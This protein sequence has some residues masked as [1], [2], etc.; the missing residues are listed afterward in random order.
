MTTTSELQKKPDYYID[1]EKC[2][3]SRRVKFQTNMR[4]KNFKQTHFTAGDEEQ[5]DRY[6]NMVNGQICEGKISLNKNIFKDINTYTSWDKYQN[7]SANAVSNTFRYLFYKFKKSIFVK[8]LNNKLSVFLP[9][10]NAQYLN[11]WSKEIHIQ[12]KHKTP[13][14]FMLYISKLEGRKY[15]SKVNPNINEWYANNCLIRYEQPLS[16]GESNISVIK[17]MLEAL[18]SK[19]K[20]DDVEFFINRRDFPLLKKNLTEPYD[21]MWGDDKKLVSHSYEKYTP[22]LS[23]SKTD[24]YADVL[25]PTYEDWSRV[26]LDDGIYFSDTCAKEYQV[27]FGIQWKDKKPIAVFRGSTT[28]CGVTINDNMRIKVSWMSSKGVKDKKGIKYLD[29]GIT[30]WNLRP[31]KLKNQKYLQTIEI[32]DLLF[33]LVEPL[34]PMEQAGYKYI[35]N[36]DGH[37]SAFR[38]SLELGMGSVVLLV[39]SPWKIWYSDMLVPYEHYIPVKED[40][41]D[42]YKVIDWCRSNDDKCEKIAKG[43]REFYDK[44]LSEKSILD[45]LQKTL[46]DIKKDMGIYL[47]NIHTPLETM[48]E[49]ERL[50]IK[51][52]YPESQTS[53]IGEIPK[54][55]RSY[56]LL[57]GI[58]WIIRKVIMETDFDKIAK[59]SG[60]IFE[61]KLSLIS[62]YKLAGFNM[63]VKS[64]NDK[65]KKLE[66][67][68]ETYIGTYCINK[69]LM[70]IPNFSY[71]FG[72][73]EKD[74]TI[75]LV[76]EK[77]E[78]ITLFQYMY[79]K[80]FSMRDFLFIL[81]QICLSLEVAQSKCGFVH[82]DLTPW[83]VM[84][85]KI[86]THIEFDYPL[87]YDK[88]I[89]VK[90]RIIPILIDYGKSHVIID[91]IHH[92]FTK[93][94]NMSTIY[95]IVSLVYTS[96][97]L[98]IDKPGILEEDILYLSN[99]FTGGSYRPEK[100]TKNTIKPFFKQ[101]SKYSNLISTN[102]YDLEKYTPY[103]MI[104]YIMKMSKYSFSLG[105]IKPDKY[106]S[107]MD[108]SN[109]RQVFEYIL[110]SNN[111]ERLQ[112]YKNVFIRI[113]QCTIP[114]SDNLLFNYYAAQNLYAN[115]NSV[116]TEMD[117]FLL[118]F[119][120]EKTDCKRI[121]ETIV[122][123][124][125]LY[126]KLL[127][128]SEVKEVEYKIQGNFKKLFKPEYD[129]ELFS[130]PKN[131]LTL[132]ENYNKNNKGLSNYKEILECILLH[133]GDFKLSQE[134][135]R[136]Y[137]LNF[138]QLLLTN[139]IF[140]LNNTAN[141]PTLKFVSD[142]IYNNDKL[143]LIEENK[144]QCKAANRYLDL[145]DK[146]I[147]EINKTK[148]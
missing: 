2:L 12:P 64:S 113:K 137:I 115:I 62:Q 133:N 66:H 3:N 146:I 34:S 105:L 120:M 116:K 37:V 99:F 36:I 54:L 83:N 118:S 130:S 17:N 39:D 123:I 14:A 94:F 77:I 30:K 57:Q 96:I 10:S 101:N 47:Y 65:F 1:K 7:I 5:F 143:Y 82:H 21:H 84:V 98:L 28:G 63:I 24:K 43:A 38:L 145:Y 71:I 46:I 29:A 70:Y 50:N 126:E 134:D 35:I 129:Q 80:E 93:M 60:K 55:Y 127:T 27:G 138:K 114:Q 53:T 76:S 124:K 44:Y 67:I 144:S 117:K 42:L 13:E 16:E 103:D 122:F 25:I 45:Y 107:K 6:R 106:V 41:S 59:Y 102:M 8:I 52:T 125:E 140:M 139:S 86:P 11:E 100:F 142:K 90:T 75:H 68:H 18:C 56:G 49:Y 48:I 20:V 69:L 15:P 72:M 9:F 26:K 73:Y 148:V 19:R 108:K 31:R 91:N 81:I 97:N 92:G 89:R 132:I 23:M 58:E 112:S 4:Y 95:D 104:K 40:L 147:Q 32:P 131:I 136:R 79:S 121:T 88:I 51:Y 61:N 135:R 141:Y 22:I 74:N 110:S 85:Q 119:N 78:G 87:S 109:S 33:N 128:K 111:E